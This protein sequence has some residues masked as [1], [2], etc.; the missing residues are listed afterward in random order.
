LLVETAVAGYHL[1]GRLREHAFNMAPAT[2]V[3][4]ILAMGY[5]YVYFSKRHPGFFLLLKNLETKEILS[6]KRYMMEREKSIG[7]I[8]KL[9]QRSIEQKLF[10]PGDP[11]L[12]RAVLQSTAYGLAHLYITDQVGLIAED[13]Q[14]DP[15][16]PALVLEKSLGGFLTKKGSREIAQ[17][18]KDLFAGLDEINKKESTT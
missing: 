9:I 11:Q 8:S 1:Q 14:N 13:H 18:P 15:E 2:P 16:F 4:Q 3:N 17:M 6:S 12:I 5:A 7:L 10:T